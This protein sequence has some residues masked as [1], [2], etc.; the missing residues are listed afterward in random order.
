[1]SIR[2]LSTEL[3]KNAEDILG[4]RPDNLLEDIKAIR[5]WIEKQPY[6]IARDDE[7]FIVTFLRVCKFR[8]EET[9]RRIEAYLTCKQFYSELF[10]IRPVDWKVLDIVR[11]GF[12]CALPEPNPNN[13]ARIIISQFAHFNPQKHKL[14]DFFKVNFM[15][16]EIMAFEDDVTGVNGLEQVIDLKNCTFQ[17]TLHFDPMDLKKIYHYQEQCVPV[18]LLRI[19][20]IN[21]RRELQAAYKLANGI[22]PAD[23]PFEILL[24]EKEEDLYNFIPLESLTDE[25]GGKNGTKQELIQETEKI[26]QDHVEYFEKDALLGTNEKLRHESQNF[27]LQTDFGVDGSFRKLEVD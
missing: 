16:F 26:F 8:L 17:Q 7:Q 6:L 22:L 1:M 13:G 20:I 24:H 23:I 9:K 10:R 2:Q 15:L 11:S 5:S 12:S 25:Y 3:A 4:E 27:N 21:L 14:R 19:H 18:R